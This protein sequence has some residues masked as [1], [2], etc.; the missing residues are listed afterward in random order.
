MKKFLVVPVLLICAGALYAGG[1]NSTEAIIKTILEGGA[2]ESKQPPAEKKPGMDKNAA[3]TPDKPLQAVKKEKPA[4]T[5][6]VPPP[7]E[8]LLKTG[9][10]LFNADMQAAALAKFGELKTKY[11]Q[12]PFR[13]SAA[14]WTGTIYFNENKLQ[15]ALREF[16][17]V[18]E[19]SGE[20]PSSLYHMAMTNQKAGNL[21]GAI[22]YYYRVSSMFPDNDLADDS[23]LSLGYIYLNQKKGGQ[24]LETAVKIIRYYPDRDSVDD[25]YYLIGKVYEKDPTLKDFETARKIYK[26]FLR[27]SDEE[28]IPV[29]M[30]SP[31]KKRVE[32][33]LRYIE[34]TYF[35]MEN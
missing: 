27:K 15:D 31:L 21:P 33:D 25:A 2:A 35:K 1:Q 11:P 22:E 18:P 24:A 6:Q 30:N 9:I 16:S 14:V 3:V 19:G 8:A 4:E 23:L 17:S 5:P 13:D 20:Y 10:Q 12:S 7:D 26:V 34:A 28:K 29:F 32:R